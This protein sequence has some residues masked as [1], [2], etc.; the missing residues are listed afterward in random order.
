[1]KMTPQE[2][3]CSFRATRINTQIPKNDKFNNH[4]CY[5]SVS[6]QDS[7]VN[8]LYKNCLLCYL[9]SV[10]ISSPK[11]TFVSQ[12][13]FVPN[14]VFCYYCFMYIFFLHNT[15][16]WIFFDYQVHVI[17]EKYYVINPMIHLKKLILW[18][19]FVKNG[20]KILIEASNRKKRENSSSS[21]SSFTATS[22]SSLKI[23]YYTF[24]ISVI[25]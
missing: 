10:S 1:M 8:F 6:R 11:V 13:L 15:N 24:H 20:N 5:V 14:V 4:Y 19:I 22:P 7:A 12:F 16:W 21:F 18:I 2:E 3:R 25:F 17:L 9:K 23:G